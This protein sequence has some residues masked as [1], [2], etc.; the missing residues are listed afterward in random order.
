MKEKEKYQAVFSLLEALEGCELEAGLYR[1]G[2][3][4][5]A[6][7][8]QEYQKIRGQLEALGFPIDE[9]KK[10][11]QYF[12][13]QL[14]DLEKMRK[15]ALKERRIAK[16]LEAKACRQEWDLKEQKGQEHMEENQNKRSRKNENRSGKR[17]MSR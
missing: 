5:F 13:I 2:Y 7:A 1:D 12:N 10:L 16:R 3:P 8:Y 14:C 11:E 4:E 17:G 6:G 15:A 9:V